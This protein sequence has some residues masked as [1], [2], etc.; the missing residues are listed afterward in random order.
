MQ[1]GEKNGCNYM[2][3]DCTYTRILCFFPSIGRGFTEFF[4]VASGKIGGRGEADFVSD[5]LDRKGG[6]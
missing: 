5:F 3:N 6:M 1:E 2:R 4:D